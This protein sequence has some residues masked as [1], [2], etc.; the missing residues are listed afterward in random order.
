MESERTFFRP[1]PERA[2]GSTRT[3]LDHRRRSDKRTKESLAADRVYPRL[4]HKLIAYGYG[5][6]EQVL[7]LDFD[8]VRLA[9]REIEIDE[10]EKALQH[11]NLTRLAAWGKPEDVKAVSQSLTTLE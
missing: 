1:E 8:Q 9:A 10:A 2:K 11:M 3:D 5:T 6:L 4:I 7:E